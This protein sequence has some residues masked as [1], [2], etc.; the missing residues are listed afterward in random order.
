MTAEET[1]F[2][3]GYWMVYRLADDLEPSDR[4]CP[5]VCKVISASDILAKCFVQDGVVV[6][7]HQRYGFEGH[8][9]SPNEAT[10]YPVSNAYLDCG[11]AVFETCTGSGEVGGVHVCPETACLVELSCSDPSENRVRVSR[12]ADG[13][14]ILQLTASFKRTAWERHCG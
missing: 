1:R 6:Y 4:W 2:G 8:C 5:A 13:K 7:S 14:H 12:F 9:M 3:F 10:W 11:Q